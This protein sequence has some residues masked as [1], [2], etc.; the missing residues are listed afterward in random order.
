MRHLRRRFREIEAQMLAGDFQRA[1]N[2]E[3][4]V[5]VFD[6]GDGVV[7]PV[8]DLADP[9]AQHGKAAGDQGARGGFEL[10]DPHARDHP[11]DLP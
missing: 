6:P 9:A 7:V 4:A 1:G 8:L 2:L 5:L 3:Q 11:R 10:H